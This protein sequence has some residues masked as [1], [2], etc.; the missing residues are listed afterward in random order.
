MYSLL[1]NLAF[2]R[3]LVV[4]SFTSA[5]SLARFPL[6][7][8]SS[9]SKIVL[10]KIFQSKMSKYKVYR[11]CAPADLAAKSQIV[12]TEV[13]CE[14]NA[15]SSGCPQLRLKSHVSSAQAA[16]DSRSLPPYFSY[17]FRELLHLPTSHASFSGIDLTA[18]FSCLL[19]ESCFTCINLPL[20]FRATRRPAFL[21]F[22]HS[23]PV[24]TRQD[25]STRAPFRLLRVY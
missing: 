22:A 9:G 10:F 16:R 18:N 17:Q 12:S 21:L 2:G 13:V 24:K 1:V 8:G 7:R 19:D 23:H 6:V 25:C 14:A 5:W 3:C 4:P 11:N 20:C 15:R